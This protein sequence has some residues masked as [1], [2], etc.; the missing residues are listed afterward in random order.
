MLELQVMKFKTELPVGTVVGESREGRGRKKALR[1]HT[2]DPIGEGLE[3]SGLVLLW[4]MGLCG[5]LCWGDRKCVETR[6]CPEHS[7][8]HDRHQ[9]IVERVR[10]KKENGLFDV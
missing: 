6:P 9:E 1:T 3:L 10:S 4:D 7:G 8:L 5:A 2:I